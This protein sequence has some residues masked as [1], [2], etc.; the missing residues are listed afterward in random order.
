MK[1]LTTHE[2]QIGFLKKIEGQIRGVQRMIEE[3]RYCVDILTQLH[4]I[5]G[6]IFHVEDNILRKHIEGC[7][8]QALK[9]RSSS[10]KR[11]KIDEVMDLVNRFRKH[12]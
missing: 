4:S 1:Q 8:V 6:A 11:K 10:E 2:K 12:G 9:G 3:R 5:T 7:V